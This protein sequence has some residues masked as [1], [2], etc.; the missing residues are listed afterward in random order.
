M[1]VDCARLHPDRTCHPFTQS[2]RHVCASALHPPVER[3]NDF[4]HSP[5][6]VSPRVKLYG[7]NQLGSDPPLARNC[8]Q[9]QNSEVK[10]YWPRLW[11]RVCIGETV[12][13]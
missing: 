11:A 1:P 6:L 9:F 5:P 2:A 7:V 13:M 10:N 3:K 4:A 12:P 8:I